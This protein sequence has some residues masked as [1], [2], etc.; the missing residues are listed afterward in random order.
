[1]VLGLLLFGSLLFGYRLAGRDLWSSHEGRAAQDAQTVLDGEHGLPRLFDKRLDLQKPPLYYWLVAGVAA[2]RG[3]PVDA[4]AV[5][6]P[7]TL[8]A[9]AGVLGLYLFGVKV[10]R[11][12][13]G[14]VAALVLATAVH[15]T[16]LART[17]RIDMP[18]TLG[19]GVAVGAFY[20]GRRCSRQG[21][22]SGGWPLYLAGYLAAA[23]AVLLKGPVGFLLPAAVAGAYLIVCRELPAP[24]HARRWATLAHELGLW[25]GVPLV[26]ALTLPWFIWAGLETGGSLFTTFFWRHH[27]ERLLGGTEGMRA[28]PWYLYGPYLAAYFLPWSLCLPPAGWYVWKN[29]HDDEARFG[30][31]WLLTVVGVLS[32]AGFKRADYLLP[33]FPGAALLVGCAAEHLLRHSR[34]P[35]RWIVGLGVVLAGCLV[36]WGVY[37]HVVLPR[38]EPAREYQRFAAA[39]RRLVPAPQLVLFFRAEAHAL[40]FHLGPELD[41]FLEWE[42]L[43]VWA[44]RPGCHYIVMPAECAAEWPAHVRSGRLEEVLRSTDFDGAERRQ[45]PLVLVRTRPPGRAPG[46]AK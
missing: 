36:G 34:S 37:L 1:V 3:G 16:W 19:V 38:Q 21:G 14:L 29:R 45:R 22:V 46:A 35:R 4:W 5:R 9:L 2:L 25:W 24:W 28:R 42:N 32:A 41:T 44:G 30:L 43:D 11:P 18:L 10:R 7:A 39:I 27:V 33:A 40:A 8:S 6:L 13:A 31:V 23:V 17:G 15:Y 26:L 20:V 12:V